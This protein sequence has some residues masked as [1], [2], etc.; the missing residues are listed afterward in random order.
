MK[1]NQN[2]KRNYNINVKRI[3]ALIIALLMLTT[4]FSA[5]T[6]FTGPTT[7][8]ADING[9]I[10]PPDQTIA[11][12]E[13]KIPIIWRSN[14]Y[15]VINAST[16]ITIDTLCELI[17]DETADVS[18]NIVGVNASTPLSFGTITVVIT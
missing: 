3:S 15:Y 12:G 14:N 1:Y 10:T 2:E 9:D 4:S 18:E 11:I 16:P 5:L 7:V 13:P 17:A 8:R 6:R